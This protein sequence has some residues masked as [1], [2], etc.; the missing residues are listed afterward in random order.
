ME[1]VKSERKKEIISRF[2]LDF[3]DSIR[4]QV[5]KLVREKRSYI[6]KPK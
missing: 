4:R 2:T 5:T 1:R 3:E 6:M